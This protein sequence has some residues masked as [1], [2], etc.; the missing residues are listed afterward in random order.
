MKSKIP[1]IDNYK[2]NLKVI[3]FL[4]LLLLI[5]ASS[6]FWHIEFSKESEETFLGFYNFR[7][8]LYSFG[9]H[10]ILFGASVFFFWILYLIPDLDDT[11]K[12]IKKIGNIG[13]GLYCSVA[14]YYLFYIFV[15]PSNS[16]Y[17]DYYYE[18]AVIL[19]SLVTSFLIYKIFNF[20]SYINN[21]KIERD[22]DTKKI[23]QLSKEFID[24]ASKKLTT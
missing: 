9:T 21:L 11:I 7:N 3:V 22:A 4:I 1:E 19:V 2:V 8:F 15:D 5:S 14:C 17:P 10:F 16:P 6:P 20:M 12:K 23:I 18:I 24:E 13:I